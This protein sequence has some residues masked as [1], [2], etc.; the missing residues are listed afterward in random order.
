[1]QQVDRPY[2][3]S[4]MSPQL[5]TEGARSRMRGDLI[6][7]A[8]HRLRLA[9]VA[10]R[11]HRALGGDF[12]RSHRHEEREGGIVF[13]QLTSGKLF[14]GHTDE[15]RHACEHVPQAAD[16][17]GSLI[18]LPRE[19]SP[20]GTWRGSANTHDRSVLFGCGW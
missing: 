7:L 15:E 17:H 5:L 10:G 19:Q 3:P 8:R 1:V 2:D 16:V 20:A 18:E 14:G 12:C 9:W 4:E 11:S 6:D 13:L